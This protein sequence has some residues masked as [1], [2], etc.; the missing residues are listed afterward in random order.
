M[1]PLPHATGFDGLAR[2][3]DS[4]MSFVNYERWEITCTALAELLP[5]PFL[6]VDFACG[7]GVLVERMR[8]RGWRSFGCDISRPMLVAGRGRRGKLPLLCADLR[9]GAM[10]SNVHLATCLFDSLNFLLDPAEVATAFK[11]V[12]MALAPG[13]VLYCDVVTERMILDHFVGPEWTER[14]GRMTLNWKT[15]YERKTTTAETTVRVNKGE[16]Q[17]FRER[18]YPVE[19]LQDC[20]E[21]AGLQLLGSYDAHGWKPVS[22]NTV[23]IDF[24]AAK[25]PLSKAGAKYAEIERDIRTLVTAMPEVVD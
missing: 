25:P 19:Y 6:H 22:K 9:A 20:I 15:T 1:A 24:V 18:V 12:A 16:A 4:M 13:G 3:Y 23:R 14:N 5:K 11:Q 8:K 21:Q 10:H 2:H 7:T 17:V